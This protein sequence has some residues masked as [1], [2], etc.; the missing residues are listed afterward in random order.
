M[1]GPFYSEHVHTPKC[2]HR[3]VKLLPFG[4]GRQCSAS[5]ALLRALYLPAV[6]D[7]FLL[8]M[9]SMSRCAPRLAAAIAVVALSASAGSA[10]TNSGT[11]GFMIGAGLASMIIQADLGT[12]NSAELGVGYH[13][14]VAYGLERPFLFFGRFSSTVV[15][16]GI[17]Y[18]L[19]QIDLGARYVFLGTAQNLRPYVELGIARREVSQLNVLIAQVEP[20]AVTSSTVGVTGGAGAHL[21]V[22]S[23]LAIDAAVTVAPGTFSEWSAFGRPFGSANATTLGIRAGIKMWPF[24]K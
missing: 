18:D 16:S 9:C 3:S 14:E 10:Q 13:A 5:A 1:A 17:D 23:R 12:S 6:T 22:N 7:C 20:S 21:F 19:T 4:A 2:V 11:K 8:L 24:S 15:D